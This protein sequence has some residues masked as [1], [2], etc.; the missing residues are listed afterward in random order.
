MASPS[1]QQVLRLYF[2]LILNLTKLVYNIVKYVETLL[3]F[4]FENLSRILL[5]PLVLDI[6]IVKNI[7]Y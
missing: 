1:I 4:D 7:F 6:N 3:N 2:I 5:L